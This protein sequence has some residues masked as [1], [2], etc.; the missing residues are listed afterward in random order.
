[1]IRAEVRRLRGRIV[2]LQV[3]GH[4][5][6]APYGQDLVCAAVSAIVQTAALGIGRL[7]T[8]APPARVREGDL[9][10]QGESGDAGQII[11]ETCLLGLKDIAD[12]YPGA[13]A[14]VIKEEERP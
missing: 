1:M 5:G 3:H 6:T 4:A 13:I 10:W 11:L 9:L 7:D 12:S 8:E 14:L 2:R